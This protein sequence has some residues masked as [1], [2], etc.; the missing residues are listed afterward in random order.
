MSAEPVAAA[1]P[2]EI[3]CHECD[4][5][6]VGRVRSAF[7]PELYLA[8][9][10]N[11]RHCDLVVTKGGNAWMVRDRVPGEKVAD[12][13]LR[14]RHVC[15]P[16]PFECNVPVGGGPCGRPARLFAGGTWCERHRP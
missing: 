5:L 8:P 11:P 12:D 3:R 1:G 10:T 16:H 14:Q 15:R 2:E 6:V 9:V 7:G 13:K 4:E